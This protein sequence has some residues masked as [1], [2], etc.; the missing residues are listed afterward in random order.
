MSTLTPNGPVDFAPQQAGTTSAAVPLTLSN[1]G[2]LPL[3]IGSIRIA[4][5]HVWQFGVSNDCG[6]SLAAGASCTIS[7]VAK[8]TAPGAKSATLEVVDAT[9]TRT[10]ALSGS[11]LP[12]LASTLSATSLK[13]AVQ[14]AGTASAAQQVTL[15]NTGA[16]ALA[17]NGITVNGA[18]AG[19]FAQSNTCGASVAPGSNCVIDV[20]FGP[21]AAGGKSAMLTVDDAAGVKTVA[22]SGTGAVISSTLTPNGPVDFAPQQAGTTSAAIPLTLSNTGSLPLAI[23]SIKIATGHVWQFGVSNDCGKSL[24]AGAS[25][26]ISVVA[27][28]T[29]WGAK[30]ATLEVVDAAGTYTI[31]LSGMGQ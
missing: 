19:D 27:K 15:S 9:G 3:A 29:A 8:P 14:M 30:S 16:Q 31:A 17:I 12:A 18:N 25:C 2:S 28:P 6:K 13:Y 26:T 11:G 24:A 23:S 1:T 20:T 4:T 5:G 21:A 22:L 10:I 7:V